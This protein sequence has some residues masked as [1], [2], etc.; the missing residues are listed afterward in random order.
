MDNAS[1]NDTLIGAFAIRCA[2]EGIEFHEEHGRMRCMPHT[3]HL[4]ALKVMIKRPFEE[5]R[6]TNLTYIR[7]Y[8]KPSV[9]LQQKKQLIKRDL[10]PLPTRTA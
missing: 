10:P 9:L 2:S 1:N 4:A 5:R 3:V 8:S 7:S 6:N